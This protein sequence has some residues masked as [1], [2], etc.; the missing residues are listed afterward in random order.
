MRVTIISTALL[1]LLA[2]VRPAW[3]Q[4]YPAEMIITVPEVDVR[5]GPT[6][7]YYATGKLRYGE[8]VVV[9]RESKDQP[10][11]LAIK[12]PAGSFSWIN[13]K[14]VKQ[15]D[16]RTGYVESEGNAQVAVRPGSSIVNKAP[17]VESVK[18][19]SGSIVTILDRE[20]NAEGN[21]WLPIQPPPT[22]VRF[23]P[24]DAV[25]SR[26]LANNNLASNNLPS[27]NTANMSGLAA[28]PTRPTAQSPWNPVS[29][30]QKGQVQAQPASFTNNNLAPQIQSYPAQWSQYGILRKAP[31]EKDGK[32]VYVLENRQGQRLLYAT[33]QPGMTLRDYVGRTVSL[34][35]PITYRSDDTLRAHVL[36]A[37]HVA[38]P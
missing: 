17:D 26:Q 1:G 3:A 24:G 27:N 32:P 37:T 9:L 18:I 21:T 2:I 14:A 4:G 15:V 8:R 31:F 5:S 13:A 12:P 25:Q 33:C 6:K 10:G 23:I 19:P 22:E 7:E 29:P 11:W 20:V 38:M 16:A 36:I 30:Q 34:Y 35:G 28:V